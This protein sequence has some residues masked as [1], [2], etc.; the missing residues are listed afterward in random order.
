MK[1][2]ENVRNRIK[3]ARLKKGFTQNY[4]GNKLG[5]GQKAYNRMETGKSQLKVETLLKLSVILDVDITY[6][7]KK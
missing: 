3:I 2:V 6:F 5:N 1:K 4:V 7:L